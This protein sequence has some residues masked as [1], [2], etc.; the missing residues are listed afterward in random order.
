MIKS[1][2]FLVKLYDVGDGDS[3]ALHNKLWVEG[4]HGGHLSFVDVA[5]PGEDGVGDGV[6]VFVLHNECL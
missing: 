2:L 1:G 4:N 5:I 6:D 3:D